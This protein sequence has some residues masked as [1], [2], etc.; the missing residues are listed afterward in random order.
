MSKVKSRLKPSSPS[1]LTYPRI[2]L[3]GIERDTVRVMS[4][5]PKN[6]TH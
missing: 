1:S 5:L 4:V 2:L 6:T 3:L